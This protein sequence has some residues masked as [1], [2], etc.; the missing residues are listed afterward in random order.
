MLEPTPDCWGIS[1]RSGVYVVGTLSC[2]RGVQIFATLA[3]LKQFYFLTES[4]RTMFFINVGMGWASMLFGLLAI[5]AAYTRCSG[6]VSSCS[7]MSF[8]MVFL[9]TMSVFLPSN[10]PEASDWAAIETGLRC[11]AAYYIWSFK[12]FEALHAESLLPQTEGFS[13]IPGGPL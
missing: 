7:S 12:C 11:I 1:L 2:L 6:L 3:Y 13:Q 8:F 9:C 4:G 10:F 5:F